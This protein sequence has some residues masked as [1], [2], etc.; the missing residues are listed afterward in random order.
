MLIDQL[1][2]K[3]FFSQCTNEDA[4]NS[5]GT[6]F[7]FYVGFDCTAKS[8]H[9]GNLFQVM[10]IRYLQLQGLKPI[11]VIGEATTKIGDPTGKTQLRKV[12]DQKQIKE[13]IEGIKY[14]LSK[15]IDFGLQN[16]QALLLSNSE[17][18]QDLRYIDLLQEYG[19]YFSVNKMLTMD[20]VK[21]RLDREYP[22]TFLEFNYMLLQALDFYHLHKTYNC[23]LQIGG[24]DQWGNIL[25][26]INLIHKI[27]KKEA[28]GFTTPL[29]TTSSGAKMGKSIDGAV[30][31]NEDMLSPYDYFQYWRNIEDSDVIRFAEIYT[32]ME[33]EEIQDF[34][35][36]ANRDI[37]SAKKILAHKITS[38]CHGKNNADQ[39]LSTAVKVFENGAVGDN[40]PILEVSSANFNNG[41]C[42]YEAISAIGF[43]KS[44]SE[45]KRLII[46]GA[47]KV[48]NIQIIEPLIHLDVGKHFYSGQCKIFVGKKKLFIIKIV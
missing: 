3:G 37:N 12:L 42:L 8:L 2:Q 18:L 41:F 32:D 26:G 7:T 29:I 47:I 19:K 36:L 20:S 9:V 22:L 23:M 30:W 11:I 21:S 48:N 33:G 16:N 44:N 43:V 15:F 31:L 13:N 4:L 5:C 35:L 10:L 24:S 34:I 46:A 14:S 27:T 45:A 6:G 25:M 28:Y 17:W 40:I 38:L 39:A 1:K